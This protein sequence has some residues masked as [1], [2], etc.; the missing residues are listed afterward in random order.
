MLHFNSGTTKNG[1][2]LEK[3]DSLTTFGRLR[4]K[5]YNLHINSDLLLWVDGQSLS[6]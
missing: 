2:K 6:A 4:V 5:G 3:P 1:T